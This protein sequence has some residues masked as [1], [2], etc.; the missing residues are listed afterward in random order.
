MIDNSALE[1]VNAIRALKEHCE[2]TSD[3]VGC[4]KCEYQEMCRGNSLF[5]KLW[6]FN[7]IKITKYACG[8][9]NETGQHCYVY[10]EH[11]GYPMCYICNMKFVT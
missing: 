11:V 2:N 5:P 10:D 7:T 1:I 8:F 6:D 4:E 9:K 3:W